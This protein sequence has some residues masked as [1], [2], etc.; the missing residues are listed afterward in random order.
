LHYK[1][2]RIFNSDFTAVKF[3]SYEYPLLNNYYVI[4]P[5]WFV[6]NR[7]FGYLRIVPSKNVQM[8]PLFALQL[9]VAGFSNNLPGGWNVMYTAGFAPSD[10]K[11]RYSF[12]KNAISAGTVASILTQLQAGVNQGSQEVTVQADGVAT[13][14]KWNAKGAFAGEIAAFQAQYEALKDDAYW[15]VGGPAITTL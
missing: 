3:F 4:D 10:Y 11:G 15:L 5:S 8:L 14:Q 13:T 1:P 9:A 12:V 6:E 7:D 2:L